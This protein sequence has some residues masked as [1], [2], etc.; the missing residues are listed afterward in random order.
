MTVENTSNKQ[1]AQQ[2]GTLYEYEFTFDILLKDPTATEAMQ[3]I[4]AI[5][6]DA[7][8]VETKLEYG[9]DYTVTLNSD[10]SGGHITV[11]DK[12]TSDYTITIYREHTL[13]QEADYQDFNASPAETFEQCFD[14]LTMLEQQQQE[15]IDRCVKVGM[16]SSVDPVVLVEQVERIYES[17]D[18]VDTVADIADDVQTVAD[19]DTNVTIVAGVSNDV[20]TVAGIA[21]DVT[22]VKNNA[23]NVTTVAGSISNVN[24]VGT[25]IE[26]VSAVAGDLTNIDAV[27]ENATNINAVAGDLTNINAVAGD[28]SNIDA[29]STNA[30]LSKQYAIGEPTEPA[31]GSAKYWAAQ[32]ATGQVQSNW[33]E[34]DNTAKSYIQNKPRIKTWTAT[35]STTWT[36]SSAPYSQAITLSGL[37]A[38]DNVQIA[39]IPSNASN[40]TTTKAEQK[41]LAKIYAG[42]TSANTL[43]LYAKSATTQQISIVVWEVQK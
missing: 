27:K 7:D 34:N 1:T 3:A 32:A 29:A 43:T 14:K 36:G 16:T 23:A 6:T 13:K 5:V 11:V 4:K 37:L 15:E 18:N 25:D 17:I 28:L 12:K 38:T 26:N 9:T 20:T 31:E 30:A 24:A 40:M 8:G 41:E 10:R 35:V 42:V 39:L 2:M 19:N 21:D 22:A 33:D